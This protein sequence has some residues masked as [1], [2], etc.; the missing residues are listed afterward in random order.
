MRFIR[1][2]RDSEGR[3]WNVMESV[4]G[5]SHYNERTFQAVTNAYRRIQFQCPDALDVREAPY[6]PDW[7]EWPDATLLELLARAESI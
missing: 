7:R 4:A 2:I 6:Y 1:T 3:E 5:I